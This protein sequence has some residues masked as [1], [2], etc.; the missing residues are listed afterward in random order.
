MI[1][2]LRL[3]RT[4][5]LA[6]RHGEQSVFE[7]ADEH[8][9]GLQSLRDRLHAQETEAIDLRA[10]LERQAE[11]ARSVAAENT[12]IEEQRRALQEEVERRGFQ[13]DALD[14]TRVHLEQSVEEHRRASGAAQRRLSVALDELRLARQSLQAR[15]SE[16][17]AT[18]A[19]LESRLRIIE[20]SH[21]WRFTAPLRALRRATRS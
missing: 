11:L 12:V 7:R 18:I 16:L 19:S 2:E 8:A 21:S 5:D 4:A 20:T 13:I 6:L 3:D 17:S 14:A 9:H 15:E 10:A 1:A